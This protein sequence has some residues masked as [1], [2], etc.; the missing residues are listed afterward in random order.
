M[1]VI[2]LNQVVMIIILKV[3][4]YIVKSR[5][6]Y[7]DP[8]RKYFRLKY[9]MLRSIRLVIDTAL[10]YF[11]WEYDKCFQVYERTLT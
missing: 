1:L 6:D 9:D 7:K 10:H 8:K 3:G 5:G 2:F 11:G 4:G